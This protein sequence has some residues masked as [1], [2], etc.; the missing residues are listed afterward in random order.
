MAERPVPDVRGRLDNTLR[1]NEQLSSGEKELITLGIEYYPFVYSVKKSH[2]ENK[3][4]LLLLDEPDVHLHPDLQYKLMDLLIQAVDGQ[5]IKAIVATHCTAI[6]GS[7]S[8]SNAHVYF[9]TNASNK[10]SFFSYK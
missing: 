9:M 3:S 7:L 10:L 4:A 6:V 2:I 8:N 5:Q 1:T